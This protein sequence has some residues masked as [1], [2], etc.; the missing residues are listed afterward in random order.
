MIRIFSLLRRLQYEELTRLTIDGRILDVGG[1]HESGYHELIKGTHTFEVANI[2][3]SPK[4]DFVFDAQ[5]RFPIE[6]NVYSGVILLNVLEHLYNYKNAVSESFRV[7]KSGGVLVGAVP[8]L[9]SVHAS[10]DDYFRYTR[11]AL[12]QIFRDAGYTDIVIKELGTGA[13]SVIHHLLFGLYYFDFIKEL[14]M[15]ICMFL[16]SIISYIKKDSYMSER[17]MP[18]GYF[19]E[20]KKP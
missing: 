14:A 12:E 18:L 1:A 3:A 7:L 5:E 16:D 11:S 19:F 10:P 8:F 4:V 17:S 6:D 13:F 9:F 15:K 20:A 2:M